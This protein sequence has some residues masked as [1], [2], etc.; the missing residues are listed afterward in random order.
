MTVKLIAFLKA[1]AGLSRAA[2]IDRYEKHHVPLVRRVMPGIVDYRRNYLPG[3][4]SDF[5][6]VTELWFGDQAGFDAAMAAAQ[7][8]PGA[9]LIAEDEE[10]IFD[11]TRTY[12]CVVEERGG[13]TL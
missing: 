9:E 7:K 1:R 6:V 11:R 5:D 4:F 2:F 12:V 3:T 8:S 13:P 10:K